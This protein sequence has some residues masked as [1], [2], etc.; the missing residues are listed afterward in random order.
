MRIESRRTMIIDTHIHTDFSTDSKMTI[1][2]AMTSAKTKKLGLTL[3]EHY[4]LDYSEEGFRCDIPEYFKAYEK[5]RS[6]ELLLGIE[7]GLAPST[8]AENEKVAKENPFDYVLGSIHGVNGRDIFQQY[9]YDDIPEILFY[10][11]YYE[12]MLKCVQVYDQFDSLAH[13]DYIHRYVQFEDKEIR[14]NPYK[15]IIAEVITTLIN[16]G[17][18]I[19]INT[20]RLVNP[21]SLQA[22][23]EVY[24]L[25]KDLG[26]Q[27]VTIGSDS[28][29][30]DA[31]GVNFKEAFYITQ[32]L[33][34]KPV[35]FKERQMQYCNIK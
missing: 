22:L 23:L 15:D 10:Q 8:L 27:Y 12:Y 2:E 20:R 7:I 31:I 30:A 14:L 32:T 35:Y 28:H 25:Y 4:D 34:L 16:K 11:Q 3:T 19:E 9:I 17:K 5:Y 1:E 21:A 24:K 29:T 33:N 13:I 6:P 26:G 18:A